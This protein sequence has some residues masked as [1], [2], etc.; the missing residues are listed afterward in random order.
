MPNRHIILV[1]INAGA[2]VALQ[3]ALVENVSS[4]VCMGL[5]FNTVKGV[6]GAPDDRILDITIPVLFVLGENSARSRYICVLYGNA[7]VW[8]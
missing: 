5:A 7:R 6:R 3:V 8:F 4:I 1:G 2:A